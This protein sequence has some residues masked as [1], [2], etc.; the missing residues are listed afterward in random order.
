M[1]NCQIFKNTHEDDAAAQAHATL[2]AD[3]R[4]WAR[5]QISVRR[6]VGELERVAAPPDFEFRLR[7]RLARARTAPAT[8]NLWWRVPAGAALAGLLVAGA[9]FGGA[10]NAPAARVVQNSDS[11]QVLA[12]LPAPPLTN[13]PQP[14]TPG[15]PQ[16]TP[17]SGPANNNQADSIVT[18]RV[19]PPTTSSRANER[20]G[21]N[22]ATLSRRPPTAPTLESGVISLPNSQTRVKVELENSRSG[23]R[24][25]FID[26]LTFGRQGQARPAVATT[27]EPVIW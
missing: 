11:A 16:I 26:T 14:T 8:A 19:A 23:K 17:T 25:L 4:T 13:S 22:I 21:N 18:R 10:T 20:A 3:C 24:A 2:C 5:E 7:A 27:P 15:G 12:S 9:W 1:I 6:L